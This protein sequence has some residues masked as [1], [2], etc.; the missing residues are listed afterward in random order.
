MWLQIRQFSWLFVSRVVVT[1]ATSGIGLAYAREVRLVFASLA[2]Q[3]AVLLCIPCQFAQRGMNVVVISRSYEDLL[4]VVSEIRK[5][6]G[7]VVPKLLPCT[8]VFDQSPQCM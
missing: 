5:P 4:E 1:G 8:V 3:V 2:C 7:P 6:S